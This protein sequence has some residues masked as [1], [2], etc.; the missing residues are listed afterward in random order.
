MATQLIAQQ[1]VLFAG[2]R[3]TAQVNQIAEALSTAVLDATTL[4]NLTKIH[5]PG[6]KGYGFSAE[7]LYAG[8]TDAVL[9]DRH[10]VSNVPFTLGLTDGS[11][12]SP[13]RSVKATIGSHKLLEGTVGELAKMSFEFGAQAAPVTGNLL[14]NASAT[15]N[16]TGT[17]FQLGAVSA[18]HTPTIAVLNGAALAGLAFWMWTKKR[19]AAAGGGGY[20]PEQPA[21]AQ[22]I[23][24]QPLEDGPRQLLTPEEIAAMRGM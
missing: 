9:F 18:A 15:G 4:G 24:T 23:A 6:L 22:P 20:A 5:E 19:N 2:Y 10:R 12:G 11:A 3:L 1:H 14:H 16:V 13:A 21:P 7:G 8:A 17:A